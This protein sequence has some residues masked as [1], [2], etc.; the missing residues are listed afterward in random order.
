MRRRAIAVLTTVLLAMGLTWGTQPATAQ[1]GMSEGCAFVNRPNFDGLYQSVHSSDSLSFAAGDHLIFTANPPTSASETTIIGFGLPAT[2]ADLQAVFPGTIDYVVP[3]NTSSEIAW[4]AV[5][6]NVTWTVN[7]G[8]ASPPPATNTNTPTNTPIPTS[9]SVPTAQPGTSEGCALLNR[10]NFDKRYIGGRP[11][12]SFMFAAGDHLTFTAEPP[13]V[14]GTPTYIAFAFF[15][16]TSYRF[17]AFP[18][19][20]DYVVPANMSSEIMWEVANDVAAAGDAIWAVSCEP[21]PSPIA[22]NTNTPTS[23]LTNTI[24]P[25]STPA[26]SS[27]STPTNTPTRTVTITTTTS[28]TPIPTSKGKPTI[29]LKPTKT[30]KPTITP[31]PTKVP[32]A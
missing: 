3:V 19:T 28:N 10:P 15:A 13:A 24:T 16:T 11:E 26:S 4:E 30:P 17:S 27:T 12:G 32:K 18:G 7:C 25:T 23:K 5:A 2:A 31:K 6:G 22:T 21:G 29:T 1:P 9:K 8:P 20:V 14:G